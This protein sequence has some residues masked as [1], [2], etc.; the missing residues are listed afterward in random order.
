MTT[1][2]STI[3]R[4]DKE[5]VFNLVSK[6]MALGFTTQESLSF[7]NERLDHPISRSHYFRIKGKVNELNHET[8]K[9][10]VVG[11]ADPY[12]GDLFR[13]VNELET[14]KVEHLRL[15]ETENLD[16]KTR[17]DLIIKSFELTKSVLELT[18]V[19]LPEIIFSIADYRNRR[20]NE[21]SC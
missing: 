1:T 11:H 10:Y 13:Q 5:K 4:Q 2:T 7:I 14:L 17:S 12:L 20:R 18:T 21:I 6:T 19:K 8:A 9:A 3:T 15:H 16:V